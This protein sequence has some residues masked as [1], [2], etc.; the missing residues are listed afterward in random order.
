MLFFE[1]GLRDEGEIIFIGKT[2]RSNTK[3]LKRRIFGSLNSLNT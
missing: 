3:N 1:A 2:E